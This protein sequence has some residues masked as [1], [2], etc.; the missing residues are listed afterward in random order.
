MVR[1]QETELRDA[2]AGIPFLHGRPDV[3]GKRVVVVG[4]WFGLNT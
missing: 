4:H 1:V 2:A 3:N